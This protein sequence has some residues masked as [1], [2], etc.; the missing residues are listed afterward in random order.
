MLAASI[1]F[2]YGV[3]LPFALLAIVWVAR[4]QDTGRAPLGA[5]LGFAFLP[6]ALA[7]MHSD[8]SPCP[9]SG[10]EIAEGSWSCGGTNP[11][12]FAVI[13]AGIVIGFFLAWRL[14]REP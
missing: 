13:A 6:A 7:V 9:P 1:L 5:A 12:P 3:A 10:I 4:R 2:T 11:L 14:T 8:Y